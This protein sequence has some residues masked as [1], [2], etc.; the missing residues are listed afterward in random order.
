MDAAAL[1]AADV[2]ELEAQLNDL[3]HAKTIYQTALYA[4]LDLLHA[5]A[6]RLLD[7]DAQIRQLL[8][9]P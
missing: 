4:A 9:R 7:Q 2:V 8:D 3:D 5:G 6:L 1:L